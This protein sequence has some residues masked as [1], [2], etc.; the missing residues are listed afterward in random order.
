MNGLT[1]NWKK[2]TRG[3]PKGRKA[4]LDRAPSV[5]EIKK[6]VEYPDRRIKPIVYTMVSS[7]IR[8]GAWDTL[9]WKHITPC[10]NDKKEL[11]AA[12]MQ[13]Y[14][15]DQEEHET[16]MT[17][18]AYIA[19]KDWMDFRSG[20]GEKITG[21]SWVMRDLWQT[22]NINYGAKLGLATY[23]K[24]LKSSGIRRLIER[25]IWEQGLRKPLQAGAKRHEWK[26]AHGFRKFF[27]THAE[28]VMNSI[29]VEISTGHD[30]GVSASYYKPNS[31]DVLA[32]YLKATPFLT[33]NIENKLKSELD[34]LKSDMEKMRANEITE[35]DGEIQEMRSEI[36]KMKEMQ[37]AMLQ[38]QID[39]VV[40]QRCK[41]MTLNG[42]KIDAQVFYEKIASD[43][44]EC[45]TDI[46]KLNR[47]LVDL[48]IS[49]Q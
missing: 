5:E 19:V 10:F 28:Q 25:A 22:S 26:A 40:M 36:E 24:K 42:D 32:D 11:I 41:E 17:P 38:A 30:I 21:E 33:I 18:E 9:Q 3:L 8:I 2:I 12:K 27:K 1:A 37:V 23:P 45:G 47:L 39:R 35:K 48:E 49:A 13:V 4:A 34:N 14:P 31:R 15:G 7:G 43:V 20:Y 16:F 44:N 29:N 6:L 46:R